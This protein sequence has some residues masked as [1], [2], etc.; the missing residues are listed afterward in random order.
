MKGEL[1]AGGLA[2]VIRSTDAHEVGRAVTLL[3]IITPGE[4]FT[5]P[6]GTLCRWRRDNPASWL[7]TGDVQCNMPSGDVFFGWCVFPPTHLMPID[8][9][10]HQEPDQLTKD[11]PAELTA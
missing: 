1:K 2:L 10:D 11:K 3:R 4:T 5:A 8:G 6:D 9:D 7:V